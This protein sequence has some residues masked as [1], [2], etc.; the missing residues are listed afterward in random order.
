MKTGLFKKRKE[1]RREDADMYLQIGG[2]TVPRE[3]RLK[4]SAA[5]ISPIES[6]WRENKIL[7]RDKMI[8]LLVE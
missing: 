1:K 5:K 6:Y 8:N 3:R 2:K 4:Y 7:N